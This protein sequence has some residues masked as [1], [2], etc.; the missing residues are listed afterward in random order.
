MK[1]E[2]RKLWS[3]AIFLKGNP[4]AEAV[5]NVITED[6][7]ISGYG[8]ARKLDKPP[9]LVQKTL[10]LLLDREL[11]SGSGDPRDNYTLTAS[12]FAAMEINAAG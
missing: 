6:L 8:I 7:G 4:L 3:G 11:I 12:G 5:F 9:A 2:F 1:A 10:I